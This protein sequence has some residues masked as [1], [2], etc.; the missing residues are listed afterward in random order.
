MES[1]GEKLR[2]AREQQGYTLDQAARETHIARRFIIAL[3]EEDFSAIP[4]EP[5]LLGF[6]RNYSEFLGLNPQETVNLYKNIKIQEQPAPID[7]LLDRQPRGAQIALP[8]GIGLLGLILITGIILFA[9]GTLRFGPGG[10]TS[11]GGRVAEPAPAVDPEA[12]VF[13]GVTTEQTFEEGD[14]VLARLRDR[15]FRIRLAEVSENVELESGDLRFSLVPGEEELLDLD[16]DGRPELTLIVRSIAANEQPPQTVIR[17]DRIVESPAA[18]VTRSPSPSEAAE[19]VVTPIGSTSEPS[20]ERPTVLVGEFAD[21]GPFVVDIDFGGPSLFRYEVDD[22]PRAEQFFGAGDS[23][24]LE[25]EENLRYWIANAGA[26]DARIAGRDI[27]LGAA[28]EVRAGLIT[29][30][31]SPSSQTFRLELVPAY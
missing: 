17:F 11:P 4:G 6:L 8:V 2:T 10:D 28:G 27:S 1:I 12:F 14:L 7:E 25:A 20:R 15:E 16:D 22:G 29:W 3:E 19:A 30:A 9:T 31:R 21:Q 24:R 5:Y 23:L 13:E 18:E 26:A